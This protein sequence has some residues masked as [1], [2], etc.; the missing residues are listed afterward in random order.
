[1]IAKSGKAIF[2]LP[3]LKRFAGVA[4]KGLYKAADSPDY[5]DTSGMKRDVYKR[6]VKQDQSHLLPQITQPTAVLWGPND[7]MTPLKLGER[8]AEAIPN[9]TLTVIPE[10]THGLHHETKASFLDAIKYHIH[11]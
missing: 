2:S 3:V 5:L 10:G 8:M 7:K 1:M 9:A 6:I 11:Q 4:R